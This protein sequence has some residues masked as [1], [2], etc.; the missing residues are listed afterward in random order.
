[1]LIPKLSAID[2]SWGILLEIHSC[3]TNVPGHGNKYEQTRMH[4]HLNLHNLHKVDDFYSKSS[5]DAAHSLL[6]SRPEAAFTE[7]K[8]QEVFV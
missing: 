3:A 6:D 2:V 8:S 4:M 1:M 5:L 7:A